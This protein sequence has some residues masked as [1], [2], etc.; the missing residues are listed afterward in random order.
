[1]AAPTIT[2]N[3]DQKRR[4]VFLIVGADTGATVTVY[5]ISSL[6]TGVV[7]GAVDYLMT[8][9]EVIFADYE[10]PQNADVSYMVEST[11]DDVV[12]QSPLSPAGQ[13]DFGGDVIFDLAHPWSGIVVNV[14]S[15]PQRDY[16]VPRDVVK[17]W[18]RSDPVVV[19]GQRMLPS[20]TLNL[21]TLTNGEA[22]SLKDTLFS[23]NTVAFSP[24]KP[25]YG[26]PSPSYYS[27]GMLSEIRASPKALEQSR[28]WSLEVQQVNPPRSSYAYPT[29]ST[30]WQEVLDNGD[31]SQI[32]GMPWYKVAG[33]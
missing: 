16:D 32:L 9:S 10:L 19:S 27:V 13:F 6:D 15:F 2:V 21:I 14:E 28:R 24:W 23:G 33:F 20:G 11:L 30:T 12:E 17:V 26:L 8:S 3:P 18:G 29:G 1:M 7:R 22:G 4:R 31:W 25:Q 5:R